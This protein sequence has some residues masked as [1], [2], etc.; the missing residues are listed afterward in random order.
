M[1]PKGMTNQNSLL[2]FLNTTLV[3]ENILLFMYCH[4]W[5]LCYNDRILLLQ[6]NLYRPQNLLHIP[7]GHLQVRF[8]DFAVHVDPS[9]GVVADRK[10]PVLEQ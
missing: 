1:L 9:S 10:I 4:N 6:P 8:A 7:F 3:E 2:D 5:L